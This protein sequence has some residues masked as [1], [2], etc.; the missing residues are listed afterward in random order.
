MCDYRDAFP[1][2]RGCYILGGF[3]LYGVLVGAFLRD[4]YLPGGV[5]L[6][7]VFYLRGR[8]CLPDAPYRPGSS[9]LPG[10]FYLS[11]RFYLPGS[12]YLAGGFYLLGALSLPDGSYLADG[13]YLLDDIYL[14]GGLYISPMSS[15]AHEAFIS[16]TASVFPASLADKTDTSSRNR[17]IASLRLA[18]WARL[19]L[20][21][22]THIGRWKLVG[23]IKKT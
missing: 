22:I 21:R 4:G 2:L 7:D 11:G 3:L 20:H 9:Y 13:F 17:S 18:G 8:P 1:P 12:F 14:P 10:A 5:Y 23:F 6:P 19:E 16:P 15:T